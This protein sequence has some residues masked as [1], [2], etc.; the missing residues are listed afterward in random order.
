MQR[1]LDSY[2]KRGC[3]QCK[4][5]HTKCDEVRPIC[6]RCNNRFINC[7]YSGRFKMK[8]IDAKRKFRDSTFNTMDGPKLSRNSSAVKGQETMFQTIRLDKR[9]VLFEK[10]DPL[11]KAP[12]PLPIPN[13]KSTISTFNKAATKLRGVSNDIVKANLLTQQNVIDF[14]NSPKTDTNIQYLETQNFIISTDTGKS[15]AFDT[16]TSSN[17]STPNTDITKFENTFHFQN[18]FSS[19]TSHYLSYEIEAIVNESNNANDYVHDDKIN[20]LLFIPQS[21]M[22]LLNVLNF[23][24]D[25]KPLS[26]ICYPS[27]LFPDNNEAVSIYETVYN[28]GMRP[29]L[30]TD[31]LLKT[32]IQNYSEIDVINSISLYNESF[33]AFCW[34]VIVANTADG[35]LKISPA[36]NFI[37]HSESL[38]ELMSQ[39][40]RIHQSS[41]YL[42]STI[43]KKYYHRKKNSKMADIWDRYV[44]MPSLKIC[45]NAINKLTDDWYVENNIIYMLLFSAYSLGTYDWGKSEGWRIHICEMIHCLQVI[46]RWTKLGRPNFLKFEQ[47]LNALYS[48]YVPWIMYLEKYALLLSNRGGTF[49][50]VEDIEFLCDELYLKKDK[51]TNFVMVGGKYSL[52]SGSVIEFDVLFKEL[53]K[54]DAFV[55]ERFPGKSIA[56]THLLKLKLTNDD[57]KLTQEMFKIGLALQSKLTGISKELD[58]ADMFKDIE[59][60]HYKESLIKSNEVSI[61]GLSIYIRYFLLNEDIDNEESII[62]DLKKL[63]NMWTSIS[64]DRDI[65]AITHWALVIGIEICLAMGNKKLFDSF[66]NAFKKC[67]STVKY[68]AIHRGV[69]KF[70][71]IEE[72][73]SNGDFDGLLGRMFDLPFC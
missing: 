7:D 24:H 6:G 4:R 34:K 72:C 20:G 2:S 62:Y 36:K 58:Y 73:L 52:I 5:A 9:R 38:W 51:K 63:L 22:L 69:R 10:Y 33:M 26:S 23:D 47:S 16:G 11:Q 54:F 19:S 28:F 41:V 32:Y 43:F 40:P 61:L 27:P 39:F 31:P 29:I 57:Q 37:H 45:L 66:L 44:R 35:I 3:N 71:M 8:T 14:Q 67:E 50:S 64:T 48:I 18:N 56:G 1:K 46:S 13:K 12:I 70:K 25:T 65:G 53:H 55:K 60:A 59:D 30:E 17:S 21:D 42:V 68:H 15:G 49:Y